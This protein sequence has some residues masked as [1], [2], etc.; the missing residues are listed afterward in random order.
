MNLTF[1]LTNEFNIRNVTIDDVLKCSL[2]TTCDTAHRH[3]SEI[4][5]I[6]CFTHKQTS[7]EQCL[8]SCLLYQNQSKLIKTLSSNLF[9]VHCRYSNI[10]GNLRKRIK[11]CIKRKKQKRP[12]C[13]L[14]IP[15]LT[16]HWLVGEFA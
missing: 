11:W 3:K 2:V 12:I 13:V 4:D 16:I 8:L 15:C 9:A 5:G 1:D 7:I 14:H 10:Y 6:L